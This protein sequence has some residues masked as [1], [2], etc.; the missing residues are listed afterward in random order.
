MTPSLTPG[1]L[2]FPMPDRAASAVD[3]LLRSLPRTDEHAYRHLVTARPPTELNPGERSDV[4]WISTETPDRSGEVVIA[5]GMDDGQYRL[6][7][8]VTLNHDY[9]L[10]AVGKS[11]WRRRV[12][13]GPFV[14]V[15]AKTR[16]PARPADWPVGEDW[17]PD[18]VHAL[19]REGM[20][21]G[22]SIGFLP[23]KVHSPDRAE[24][25]ER[26][27]GDEV[28]LVVDRWL[29]LE[30]ACVSLPANPLTLVESVTKSLPAAALAR[31]VARH[32]PDLV[33]AAVRDAVDRV[34]GRI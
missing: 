2:G 16:Y 6:N 19:V 15:K 28:R 13:D 11:L 12:F 27:W 21:C 14:G 34:R 10:P 9:A 29:L 18:R 4:S 20:L 33:A 23:L 7:P 30:Y 26:G 31:E 32:I 3:A 25:R 24:R 1:P 8:L 5:S 17:L 22:K